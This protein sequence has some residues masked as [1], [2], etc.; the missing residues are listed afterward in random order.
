VTTADVN[1]SCPHCRQE[2]RLR[3]DLERLMRLRSRVV[4]SRCRKAFDV[5]S[6]LGSARSGGRP[7]VRPGGSVPPIAER[8]SSPPKTPV[9]SAPPAAAPVAIEPRGPVVPPGTSLRAAVEVDARGTR[10]AEESAPDAAPVEA[11]ARRDTDGPPSAPPDV[12]DSVRTITPDAQQTRKL[13]R[14][15]LGAPPPPP[16]PRAPTARRPLG[17]PPPLP[18]GPPRR[19]TPKMFA[20]VVDVAEVAAPESL[21]HKHSTAP[22]PPMAPSSETP[23]PG[24]T[25]PTP[26]S[27]A[28]WIALADPGL[29]TLV[30]QRRPAS[31]ALERLVAG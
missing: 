26:E 5:A 2:Y 13:G 14:L 22:P 30:P 7:S 27:V 25:Q 18:G 4:C 8:V 12:R 16:P 10:E 24:P 6:R 28:K 17:M 1:V 20:A 9:P 19:V 15:P 31:E 11:P 29:R 21:A 3:I 23:P